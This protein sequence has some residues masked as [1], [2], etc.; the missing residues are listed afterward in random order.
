MD[1]IYKKLERER[2]KRQKPLP[3]HHFKRWGH[4]NAGALLKLIDEHNRGYA[5]R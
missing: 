3:E 4:G 5:R 2:K 1:E